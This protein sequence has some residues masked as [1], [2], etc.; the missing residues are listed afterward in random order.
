MNE[1]GKV[2]IGLVGLGLRGVATLKRY[3]VIE[4]AEITAISDLSSDALEQARQ[5]LIERGNVGVTLYQGESQWRHLCESE[6]V[7]LVYICTD[8]SSH[9]RMAVYAMQKGKH[10]AL[11]VPAAM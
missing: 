10:V 8:W 11:E 3:A 7:D 1:T 4:G 9:A 6:F 5:L 2:R